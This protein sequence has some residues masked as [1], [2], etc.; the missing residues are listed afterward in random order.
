M[1]AKWQAWSEKFLVLS[2]REQSLIFISVLVVVA[3]LPFHF[4]IDGNLK[5]AEK[6]QKRVASLERANSDLTLSIN[7]FKVALQ[8]D[9]NKQ[10]LSQIEQHEKRLAIVDEKL[11]ALTEELIDPIQMRNALIQLLDLQPGVSLIAFEVKPAEPLLFQNKKSNVKVEQ[12][13]SS[14]TTQ[15]D[16][17]EINIVVQQPQAT[18]LYKH[19][20]QLKL[21]GKY[22]QLR[23]Y[24]KQVEELPWQ[25]FWHDFQYQLQAYPKSELTIE[26]YSLSTNKEFI[27]V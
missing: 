4:F 14:S 20:I 13:E 5:Q 12:K 21:T 1:K 25:F 22:F 19:A 9:K 3:Y 2:P 15:K 16:E 27:G 10:L 7:E 8:Q 26:I 23:D 17:N 6:E 11:L 24:L 18:G